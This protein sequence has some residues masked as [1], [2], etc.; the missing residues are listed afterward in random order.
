MGSTV[1]VVIFC[2]GLLFV[3]AVFYLLVKKRI[4]ERNSLFWLMGALVILM[5]S[6]MPEILEVLA[7]MAGVDYPPTL[8]FL[9]STLVILFITLYQ[10]IQ[11]SILQERVRELTQ[12][13]AIHQNMGM[14]REE[15]PR[16]KK[17]RAREKQDAV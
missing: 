16:N 1:K 2:C 8:L 10:S 3:G 15:K 9:C 11:I 4:N 5:L 17:D 7:N 13:F 14:L 6:T 12:L